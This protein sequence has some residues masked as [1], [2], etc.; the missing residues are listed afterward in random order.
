MESQ[1]RIYKLEAPLF[2]GVGEGTDNMDFLADLSA[3]KV[4]DPDE[5]IRA[6]PPRDRPAPKSESLLLQKLKQGELPYAYC[7]WCEEDLKTRSMLEDHYYNIHHVVL[8]PSCCA[9][10]SV[11]QTIM[12]KELRL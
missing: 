11:F 2:V 12:G 10:P 8:Q 5:G 4:I 7:A 9:P 1:S 3:L 6:R